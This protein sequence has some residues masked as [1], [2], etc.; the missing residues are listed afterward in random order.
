MVVSPSNSYSSLFRNR[1]SSL[2][3]TVQELGKV[4]Y[5]AIF[6]SF[7]IGIDWTVFRLNLSSIYCFRV[8]LKP[9][10]VLRML[11]CFSGKFVPDA[12]PP[13]LQAYK[14]YSLKGTFV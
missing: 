12:F 13:I 8:R 5:R 2:I 6:E 7:V 1:F 3:V 11:L 10:L 9:V 14:A 4:T